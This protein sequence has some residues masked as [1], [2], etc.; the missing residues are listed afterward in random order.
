MWHHLYSMTAW[1]VKILVFMFNHLQHFHAIKIAYLNELGLSTRMVS[2]DS[3]TL[4]QVPFANPHRPSTVRDNSLDFFDFFD[5]ILTIFNFPL[6][7]A[8]RTYQSFI[9][10]FLKFSCWF[11]NNSRRGQDSDKFLSMHLL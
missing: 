7:K 1:K 5:F 6:K 9:I 10:E 4:H 8:R 3:F 2:L 11:R